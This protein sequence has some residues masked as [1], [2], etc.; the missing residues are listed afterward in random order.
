[1]E[2][3]SNIL[4]YDFKFKK[5]EIDSLPS[6]VF[7][8]DFDDSDW[9][10]VRIPH[11][12]AIYGEF[13]PENDPTITAV[14]ED[15]MEEETL[16][17]GWTGGLPTV[18][19]GVYR[20]WLTIEDYN[21][22]FLQFDGIMWISRVYVNGKEVGGCHFG[23]KSFEIDITEFVNKGEE[24]LI[25]IYAE[26]RENSGRWYTGAGI[27]RNV[28]L[29]YKDNSHIAYNGVF[30]RQTYADKN[31][32][33]IDITAEL[34]NANSFTAEIITPDGDIKTYAS[35]G[36][37]LIF[38]IKNPMLWD[39]SSPNLYTA[40]IQLQSGDCE[41]IKFGIRFCDFT[42]DGFFLNVNYTKIKG[43]CLHHDLGS[44][45]AAV[46]RS[47][48]KRQ[49][50]IMQNMGVNAIRTSHN[51]PAIEL[52]DL[53]DSMGL[54]VM[55]EFFDEWEIPKV[56]NGYTKF[57]KENA[58][59]D[60]LDI[61]KRDRNHPSVIMWSI[62]NEVRD[63]EVANGWKNAKLLYDAVRSA[64][65]TRPITS[66]FNY[67]PQCI[68]NHLAFYTDI[69]GLNYKPFAYGQLREKYPE[70][71]VI[72]CETASCISTRGVY[73]FPVK[74]EISNAKWD[75]L[76]VSA[77]ELVAPPWASYA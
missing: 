49:L 70:M 10:N 71:K 15:G 55:D 67:Y 6:G 17:V 26:V 34:V 60:A 42:K 39:I 37:S 12:W 72:G 7:T 44:L 30:V 64:D 18:G 76:C 28:R 23:Y 43:V 5:F 3:I 11:D 32:A 9:Q 46:N 16:M 75:D 51:P 21:K 69:V 19:A 22:V 29:V 2:R 65:P 38:D 50:E 59:K 62:G 56:K 58:V 40:K 66:G 47:A 57:F 4:K 27:F 52:L 61:I 20:K 8:A 33:V 31:N 53:C 24:N 73:H 35:S 14:T 1:M 41:E 63:Q 13:S 45:G 68:D 48:L 25:A 77:Y 54:L 74:P 36:N